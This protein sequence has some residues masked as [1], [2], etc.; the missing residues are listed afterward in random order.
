MGLSH[1]PRARQASS[2]TFRGELGRVWGSLQARSSML[3]RGDKSSAPCAATA[4]ALSACPP[5]PC[6]HNI[7][8]HVLILLAA[9]YGLKDKMRSYL[10]CFRSAKTEARRAPLWPA[11][12]LSPGA[13]DRTTTLC[14]CAGRTRSPRVGAEALWCPYLT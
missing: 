8:S 11:A 5:L 10:P 1:S 4:W 3:Y 9:L 2:T 12:P 13:E 6:G 14:G 7:I